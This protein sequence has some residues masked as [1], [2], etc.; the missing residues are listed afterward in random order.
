VANF[1][2]SHIFRS[3]DGGLTWQDVDRGRLPDVPHHAVAISRA[4]PNTIYVC[5]DVG[6]FVSRDAGATWAN[7]SGNLPHTMVVDLV[8]HE[9]DRTLMAATYGRS[10]WRLAVS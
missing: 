3:D 1:G 5:N 7:L 9:A 4:A 10:L 6:V 2:H 8:Y